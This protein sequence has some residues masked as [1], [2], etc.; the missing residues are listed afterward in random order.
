MDLNMALL[1]KAVF[2][3]V[4]TECYSYHHYRLLGH[5]VSEKDCW[6]SLLAL[7]TSVLDL[8][9]ELLVYLLV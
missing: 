1:G 4:F 8:F 2:S 3:G 6:D 7:F 9:T 5:C